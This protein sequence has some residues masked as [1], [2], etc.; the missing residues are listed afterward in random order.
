M[1]K[2][3]RKI[4]RPL[5]KIKIKYCVNKTLSLQSIVNEPNDGCYIYGLYS[6]GFELDISLK[7]VIEMKM[8]KNGPIYYEAPVIHLVPQQY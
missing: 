8:T 2:F 4:R 5:D 3:A 7:N 6:E 1:Q